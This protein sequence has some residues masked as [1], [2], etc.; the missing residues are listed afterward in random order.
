MANSGYSFLMPAIAMGISQKDLLNIKDVENEML[1]L[2]DKLIPLSTSYTQ[3][4]KVGAPKKDNSEKSEKT[5]QNQ[6]SLDKGNNN[7]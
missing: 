5:E 2:G 7:E 3:S 6:E 4:G 1:E